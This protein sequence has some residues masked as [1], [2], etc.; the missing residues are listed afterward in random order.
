MM[1]IELDG[2]NCWPD[3]KEKAE[4]QVI[5]GELAGA[6]L[7]P[8]GAITRPDGTAA[9]R[10]VVAFRLEL[11]DGKTVLAQT[12]VDMVD[13]LAASIKGRLAYLADLR[14]AGGTPS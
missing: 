4:G 1:K 11:P 7:L 6:A 2:D 14:A 8:D 12:T 5:V 13:M 3:L 9:I 10:P